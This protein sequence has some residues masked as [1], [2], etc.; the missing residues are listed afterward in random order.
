MN[1]EKVFNFIK[2]K[3][4]YNVPTLYKLLNDIPLPDDEKTKYI[5]K[6]N[7]YL[8]SDSKEP[9]RIINILLS[10]EEFINKLD[11]NGIYYL[12]INSKEPDRI[13]NILGNKGIEFINNLDSDEIKFLLRNSKVPDKIISMLRSMVSSNSGVITST[14]HMIDRYLNGEYL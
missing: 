11:S 9:D 2:E 7:L 3:K 4:G 10:S 14:K 8:L 12:L 13:I 1:L 6:M 5:N